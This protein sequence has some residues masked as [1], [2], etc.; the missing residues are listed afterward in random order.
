MKTGL[1]LQFLDFFS[2][3]MF[4]TSLYVSV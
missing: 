4:S 2:P 3:G 1:V